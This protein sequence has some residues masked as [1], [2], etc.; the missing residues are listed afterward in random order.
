MNKSI[1]ARLPFGSALL[2]SFF[3]LLPAT[4]AAA[5]ISNLTIV[6]N[7][8]N[9]GDFSD[10][11]RRAKS[12]VAI[13]SSNA[14]G[15]TTRYA[16]VSL[17][18]QG[19]TGTDTTSLQTDYTISFDVVAAGDYTLAIANLLKA[20]MTLVDDGGGDAR[21]RLRNFVAGSSHA[22]VSGTLA[23]GF[24]YDSGNDGNGYYRD[25][26]ESSSAT[27]DGTSGG[28]VV[29]HSFTFQFLSRCDSRYQFGSVG[30]GDECAVRAGIQSGHGGESASDYPGVGTRSESADGH[31]ITVALTEHAAC[32]DLH[33]DPSED[34]DGGIC[35]TASCTFT[36][37][38]TLCRGEADICDV[39]ESC[40]GAS[41]SC[42]ADGFA[43]P[44]TECLG[45]A[46]LCDI[47]ETCDGLGASCPAD[48]VT[49]AGTTCRVQVGV[50]D[51]A[52]VCDGNAKTCPLDSFFDT[53]TTCRASAGIC[54]TAESCTGSNTEC[55]SDT[56]LAAGVE[57]RALGGVCDQIEACTGASAFC[58]ADD[59]VGAGLECRSAAGNCDIAESC[60]GADP[61]CPADS[62]AGTAIQC[63]TSVDFCDAAESCSGSGP[64]CPADQFAPAGSLCRASAGACDLSEACSGSDSTCPADIFRPSGLECRAAASV[65]DVAEQCDGAGA[66]CP[67][68]GFAITGTECRSADGD[69]DIAELC[70]GA[71]GECPSDGFVAPGTEC[72][73]SIGACDAAEN[74]T[75]SGANCP[76]DA[77]A[78]VTTICRAALG[79][80]DA[81]EACSGAA[82]GCPADVYEVPGT[83]CRAAASVCDKP[84]TCV[85][86]G[87]QC[88]ADEVAAAG[89][90]CRA[91]DGLCDV[92]E[93]CDGS[94]GDCPADGFAA[95]GLVC[96]VS[97]G[98]PCD[99]AEECTGSAASCP[100]DAGLSDGDGDGACDAI[101]NCPDEANA[102]QEDDDSDG[103]GNVCD[104]CNQVAG[105]VVAKPLFKASRL[106]RPAGEQKAIF[107]GTVSALP[108]LP[109]IDPVARG[110]RFL[111][112]DGGGAVLL[113]EMLAA[114]IWNPTARIGWKPN[115]KGTVW[116]FRDKRREGAGPVRLVKLITTKA[117]GQYKVVVKLA[118]ADLRIDLADTPLVATIVVDAPIA[119]TGQC[120]EVAFLEENCVLN[121]KGNALK[122]R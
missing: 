42:P 8:G 102:L 50:C 54:D 106:D 7:A 122:C 56:L 4:D 41:A 9:S 77:F 66:V 53:A 95:T 3:L 45:A 121:A 71:V 90:L 68:D 48:I 119:A 13:Q 14:A 49:P 33:T 62:F 110:L 97:S 65:C 89:A 100:A 60:N 23:F 29:S 76:A 36:A 32:G 111:L 40:T 44:G 43:T 112:E 88:P 80:C 26:S 73:V 113:D 107:V 81:A 98:A 1:L 69:C 93:F 64:A 34:C 99:A 18:D 101:D 79:P 105:T 6:K 115:G 58:P 15:F 86:S 39:A 30:G 96:R 87:T 47:A 10:S 46:G 52:E 85:G 78:P 38:A 31:F 24:G 75:G 35:C 21:V 72:R 104:A 70:T 108:G 94:D 20:G 83:V 82:A 57:C 67:A 63:R 37:A 117:V 116:V 17:A 114:G 61:S 12:T 19:L 74:C 11:D 84:E 103:M 91:A 5:G 55:P 25:V 109:A 120:A 59:V 16:L 2:L 28:S 27:I 118:D 92:D 51:S 22:L